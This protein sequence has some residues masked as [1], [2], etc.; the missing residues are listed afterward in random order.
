VYGVYKFADS[1]QDIMEHEGLFLHRVK[2]HEF[3]TV[4]DR[5]R[6]KFQAEAVGF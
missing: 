4:L 3:E 6:A 5:D 2:C 1:K